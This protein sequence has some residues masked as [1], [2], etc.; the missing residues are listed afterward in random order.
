MTFKFKGRILRL[1]NG[2]THVWAD[3][4]VLI[5]GQTLKKLVIGCDFK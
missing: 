4:T 3:T 5:Q 1:G 2:P